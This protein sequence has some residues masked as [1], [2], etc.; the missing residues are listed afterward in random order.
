M[1]ADENWDMWAEWL[2]DRILK[3][4]VGGMLAS[5]QIWESFQE[6]VRVA[7]E[8]AKRHA[9]F[10]SWLNSGYLTNQGVA[11]RR[12][13]D[14]RGDV[15]SVGRLLKEIGRSPG[16]VTRERYLARIYAEDDQRMGNKD[17]DQLVGEG[18]EA[19]S[20]DVPRNQLSALQSEAKTVTTWVNKEVA[21][22]D[23]SD[24]DFSE[25]L[26]FG[27]V[28][29]SIDSIFRTFNYYCKLLRGNMV[30]GSVA[31]APW[32]SVFTVAWIPNQDALRRVRRVATDKEMR[33]RTGS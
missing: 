5:K 9:T 27:D 14:V 16:V 12:Q 28:H 8:E 4:V 29:R 11:V 21:H 26:T 25:S 32:E 30:I 13:L 1:N 24:G 10:H 19:L 3:D 17:F 31:L 18:E 15:I 22:F 23:S 2:D 20:S 33:G 7:P 6:I